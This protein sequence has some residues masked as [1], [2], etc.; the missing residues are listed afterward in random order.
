V[1]PSDSDV[2]WLK[3][4]RWDK[5][6]ILSW[7]DGI[8]VVYGWFQVN[9]ISRFSSGKT[10]GANAGQDEV[11]EDGEGSEEPRAEGRQLRQCLSP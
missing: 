4:S 7:I 3:A 9:L 1:E 5:S 6:P 11:D 10:H 8:R 2:I